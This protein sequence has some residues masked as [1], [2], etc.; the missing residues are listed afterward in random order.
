MVQQ[1]VNHIQE[2]HQVETIYVTV[3]ENGQVFFFV[4]P[5]MEK[6]SCKYLSLYNAH[7]V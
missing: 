2:F 4:L 3:V 1:V 5:R 7:F 6:F